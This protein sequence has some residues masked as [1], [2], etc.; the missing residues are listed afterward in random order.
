MLNQPNTQA[1][2]A[3]TSEEIVSKLNPPDSITGPVRQIFA[4]L[5]DYPRRAAL[6]DRDESL[7]PLGKSQAWDA[8]RQSFKNRL[9]ALVNEYRQARAT[10]LANLEARSKPN[11][12]SETAQLLAAT[13]FQTLWANTP[14][15][16]GERF[17]KLVKHALESQ[18]AALQHYLAS[19]TV[20]KLVQD[21]DEADK[22]Q[23]KEAMA[24]LRRGL[25]GP[26]KAAAVD[27]LE[28]AEEYLPKL[29]E[30]LAAALHFGAQ[31]Y[32][33]PVPPVQ[34]MFRGEGG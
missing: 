29:D 31:D 27:A 19:P 8:L 30:T 5:A 22:Y 28:A 3:A 4:A 17:D 2:L 21:G 18:D 9:E 33:I 20:G 23:Y 15:R 7:S 24:R 34:K 1:L 14:G 12:P 10:Y 16:L 6:I 25:A 26:E 32:K 13:N 11:P